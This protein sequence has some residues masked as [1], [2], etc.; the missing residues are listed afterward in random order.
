MWPSGLRGLV[1]P[2]PGVADLAETFGHME[3]Y[4]CQGPWGQPDLPSLSL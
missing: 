3:A 2:F 1:L 4:A